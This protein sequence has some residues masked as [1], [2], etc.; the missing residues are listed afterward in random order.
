MNNILLI[1]DDKL[2]GEGLSH[3][4]ENHGYKCTW[5]QNIKNI[6]KHWIVADLVLLDRQLAEGDSVHFLPRWLSNKAIPVIVL[7]AKVDVDQRIEGLM[8]GA[9]DYVIKPFSNLELL[10]RINAQ[11]RPLGESNILYESIDID[12]SAR[13]VRNAGQAVSMTTKEFEL[14]LLLIQNQGRVFHREEILNKIWGYQAFPTTRT[15]DN[16]ILRIR[17]K[18]PA[19]QIDTLRSIGYRL[20]KVS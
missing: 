20:V 6:E 3:F 7:T 13:T 18:L 8:A 5:L 14:L 2:L 4:L 1:E 11:L 12:I 10:A 15:V 9:K 17:K 16:H 19:L